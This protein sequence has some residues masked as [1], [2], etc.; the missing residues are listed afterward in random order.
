MVLAITKQPLKRNVEVAHDK[1]LDRMPR[2]RSSKVKKKQKAKV[3]RDK[4][5]N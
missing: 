1:R 2:F 4:P 3:N 5:F